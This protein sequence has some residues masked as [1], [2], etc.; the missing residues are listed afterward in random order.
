MKLH[1][2]ASVT[3]AAAALSARASLLITSSTSTDAELGPGTGNHQYGPAVVIF[4]ANSSGTLSSV[5]IFDQN[6]DGFAAS[7]GG[8]TLQVWR[9]NGSGSDG[10]LLGTFPF[11]GS[12]TTS[13]GGANEW[14]TASS[15][16]AISSGSTYAFTVRHSTNP[17]VSFMHWDTIPPYRDYDLGDSADF[18]VTAVYNPAITVGSVFFRNAAI[19]V[20]SDLFDT[21]HNSGGLQSTSQFRIAT[22]DFTA[23]PEPSTY[24]LV[25]G[26]GMIGFGLWRRRSVK[27]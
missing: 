8:L 17:N 26:V 10:T 22:A 6:A 1:Q 13:A 19:G 9:Q 14:M 11:I 24:A 15:S 12:P 5:G 18:G 27:A 20:G 2:F 3:L 21:S 25:A 23:V 4:T 7:A 16:I